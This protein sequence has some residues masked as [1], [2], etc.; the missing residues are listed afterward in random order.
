MNNLFFLKRMSKSRRLRSAEKIFG[1]S[2]GTLTYV[3]EEIEHAIKIKRIEY[4][5]TDYHVDE[6]SKLSACKLPHVGTPY[7]NWIDVD[8]IHD[9]KVV[10]ALG[11]Q[12]HLHPLLLEDVMNTEQKPKIDLY[13]D[14]S[15][16]T[17]EPQTTNGTGPPANGSNQNGSARSVAAGHAGETA[18]PT[19]FVTLKNAA[20]QSAAA[21]DRHRTR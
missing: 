20:P 16:M 14:G 17:G 13:D 18:G 8:G 3:G 19:V 5:A 1:T 15:A 9:P 2:P 10:A 4:N 12:Y 6:S 11:K 21:G 7:V